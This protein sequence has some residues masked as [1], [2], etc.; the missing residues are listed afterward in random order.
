MWVKMM[1]IRERV[2]GV[3]DAFLALLMLYLGLFLK[4]NI[5][6]DEQNSPVVENLNVPSSYYLPAVCDIR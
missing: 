4:K 2:F 3:I 6:F 1:N 5:Y